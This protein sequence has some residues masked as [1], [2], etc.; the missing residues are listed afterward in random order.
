MSL[1][2]IAKQL[3]L[4]GLMIF[5][6]TGSAFADQPRNWQLGYQ[7]AVTPVMEKITSFHNLLL[8]ITIG[9]TIF[10]FVLL[11]IVMIRFNERANPVPR[12]FTHNTF[13]EVIWT[14]GPILVLVGI[15]VPS[16]QLLRL[17]DQIPPAEFTIKATGYQWYWGYEYPDQG[18]F[19][20]LA[21]MVPEDE[22]QDG[23]P[24]LL[25]TD[26][27]V[28]VPVG[29]NVRMLVTA[30][31]VIHNWAI[32]AFG[33]KMDAVP[34]RINETWFRADVEGTYYGQCSE[35][36]GQRHAFMP[37]QVEV[38]SREEFNTWIREQG[39]TV[40]TQTTTDEIDV[41]SAIAN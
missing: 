10:V 37:I 14:L 25:A 20:Y 29:A 32:P 38:V 13:L 36:C 7:E 19:D 9:I 39:G 5:G 1:S 17:Q 34:G 40:M 4:I 35:L 11:A 16:M 26:N 21:N 18:G 2:R 8:W 15:L 12:K 27:A 33:V 24:R 23:Q 41:A 28:V 3:G 30:A 31:D 22:L 6:V